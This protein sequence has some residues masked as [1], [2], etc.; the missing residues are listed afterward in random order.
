MKTRMTHVP[1]EKERLELIRR[2]LKILR[3]MTANQLYLLT[4]FNK[5]MCLEAQ[6][7]ALL[8]YERLEK[9]LEK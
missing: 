1:I 4:D 6:Q 5:E 7:T 9:E 3:S 2:A 8:E